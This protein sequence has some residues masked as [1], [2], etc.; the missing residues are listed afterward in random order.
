[1]A[2]NAW[3]HPSM[4]ASEALMH[5][6][7]ALVISNLAARDKTGE[8]VNGSM[9]IGESVKIRTRPDYEVKEFSTTKTGTGPIVAQ[10]IRES[11]RPF[12]IEKILDVS[13]QVTS[14][15]KK[16]DLDDFSEQVIQPA[17]FRLAE[18]CDILLGTKILQG[19]GVYSS[20]SLYNTA[21]DIALSRKAATLQQLAQGRYCLVG[22]DLEA[23][24]LGQ[25]WFNQSQTRGDAGVA[26]L[27]TGNMGTVMGMN[28]VSTINFPGTSHTVGNGTTT[29]DNTGGANA[30]GDSALKVDSLTGQVEAGDRLAI[31]GCRR[32]VIAAAQAVATATAI[33]IVDPITE[34]VA[35]GAALTTVSSGKTLTYQGAV[36]DSQS[37]A[38]AMPPL[39]VPSDKPAATASNNGYSIRVVQGYD[40]TK[41]QETLSLDL[42]IGTTC[43]DPR[44]V[45]LLADEA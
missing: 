13:I 32:P 43:W 39:D 27:T 31:A 4:I 24:L 17:A 16:L 12:A 45:T 36:F 18:K 22:L 11:T 29:M 21:A 25:T 28:F 2:T 1:M 30:V 23:I 38:I 5:L 26:S 15:E 3:Q 8:F 40:M 10:D 7:D 42:M 19:A 34:I 9:Q 44:R 35:D 37:L 20:A 14:W 41:K 33:T 6:E